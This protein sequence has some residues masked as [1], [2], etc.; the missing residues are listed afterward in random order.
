MTYVFQLRARGLDGS[1]EARYFVF[2]KVRGQRVFGYL[3]AFP[4]QHIG[5]AYGDTAA[6]AGAVQG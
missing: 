4:M 6:D 5:L 2:D 3:G 1:L